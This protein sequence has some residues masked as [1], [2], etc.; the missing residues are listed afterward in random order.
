[1][2]LRVYLLGGSSDT[3]I[4][5][6][7][8]LM[9]NPAAQRPLSNR[10][11]ARLTVT[12]VK[13]PQIAGRGWCTDAS[14]VWPPS[15]IRRRKRQ[16]LSAA[17]ESWEGD[18]GRRGVINRP[19]GWVERIPRQG[20]ACIDICFQTPEGRFSLPT[21]SQGLRKPPNPVRRLPPPLPRS[22]AHPQQPVPARTRPLVGSSRNTRLWP[23]TT[24]HAM[25]SRRRSPPLR[26]RSMRPPGSMPPTWQC[27]WS[28]GRRGRER[29]VIKN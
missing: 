21:A 22:S 29:R 10:D 12:L 14:S 24:P 16:M 7:R 13:R 18:G 1:M 3:K 5:G 17:N 11:A 25:A 23:A 19:Y 4:R 6:E 9:N 26:P 20:G 27:G 2:M 8:L 15:A 28:G